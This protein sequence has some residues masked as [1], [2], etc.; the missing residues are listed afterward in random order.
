[1]IKQFSTAVDR[2]RIVGLCEGLSYLILLGI[3]MPLKYLAN[4]PAAVSIVGM[5]HG[6]LFICYCLTILLALLSGHISLVR[7]VQAFIA[8]LLPFGPFFMDRK[9]AAEQRSHNRM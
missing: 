9:L 1:M 2:V 3:A 8:S 5:A 6:I 4:M 7:S